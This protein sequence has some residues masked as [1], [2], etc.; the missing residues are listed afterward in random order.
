M[1][2]TL[3][4]P[5]EL[6]RQAQQHADAEGKPLSAWVAYLLQREITQ[7]VEPNPKTLVER[8]GDTAYLDEDLPA[9]ERSCDNSREIQFP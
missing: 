2:V 5:E 9:P 3:E 7:A 1:N 4:L 6:T 8:I